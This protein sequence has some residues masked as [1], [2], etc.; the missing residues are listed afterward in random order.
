MRDTSKI[1]R[2]QSILIIFRIKNMK[3][4]R[5]K[6]ERRRLRSTISKGNEGH[7]DL[8]K[9]GRLKKG[10]GDIT[11]AFVPKFY[12]LFNLDRKQLFAIFINP[13]GNEHKL[14]LST[15]I[16]RGRIITKYFP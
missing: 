11:P 2:L 13:V 4:R 16:Q 14:S 1:S 10:G 9:K 7:S 6:T 12:F 5:L 15:L 3:D 8:N